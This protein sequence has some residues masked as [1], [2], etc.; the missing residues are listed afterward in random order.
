MSLW[1]VMKFL[2]PKH[3]ARQSEPTIIGNLHVFFS[4]VL[5]LR[6]S[7]GFWS[8][9]LGNKAPKRYRDM[10]WHTRLI[11]RGRQQINMK[12]TSFW[13]VANDSLL[14]C[15]LAR[16]SPDPLKWMEIFSEQLVTVLAWRACKWGRVLSGGLPNCN[17]G[18]GLGINRKLWPKVY[19]TGNRE[20]LEAW[21]NW[22]VCNCRQVLMSSFSLT[23]SPTTNDD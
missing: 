19:W 6:P 11:C 10:T 8:R 5:Q 4:S 16:R 2:R 3:Q 21:W 18:F 15:L 1:L 17:F 14:E 23:P 20:S 12:S 22:T 13:I 9:Q 7:I